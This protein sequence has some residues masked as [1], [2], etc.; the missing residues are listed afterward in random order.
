M[1]FGIATLAFEDEMSSFLFHTHFSDPLRSLNQHSATLVTGELRTNVRRR[2][3]VVAYTSAA[4]VF[5]LLARLTCVGHLFMTTRTATPARNR[6]TPPA[7]AVEA[8]T[9]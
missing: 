9:F 4:T 7:S 3:S 8:F 6:T 5:G 2:R 1:P